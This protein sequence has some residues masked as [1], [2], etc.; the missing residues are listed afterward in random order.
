[1]DSELKDKWVSAL[2]SDEYK[3]GRGRLFSNGKYC[4]L[5]VLC[6]VAGL[7][8]AVS[9]DMTFYWDKDCNH[10]NAFLLPHDFAEAIG[11]TG[12]SKWRE[13]IYMNDQPDAGADFNDIA[14]YIEKNL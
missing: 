14:E 5:G 8:R 11:A 10:K 6:E 2:R 9:N 12:D 13:I 1:M 3:Q 7:N 4:C